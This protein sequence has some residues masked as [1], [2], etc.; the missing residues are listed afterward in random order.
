MTYNMLM[1]TLSPT[2]SLTLGSLFDWLES[3][4]S[5]MTYNQSI[6]QLDY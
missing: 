2:H 5:E 6:N 4:V 3:R 1:E